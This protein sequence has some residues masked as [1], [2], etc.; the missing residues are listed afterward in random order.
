VTQVHMVDSQFPA[1]QRRRCFL[2]W[3]V[4]LVTLIFFL[5][6]V[7]IKICVSKCSF[8]NYVGFQ[9]AAT[10]T[11][12]VCK[13]SSWQWVEISS[14]ISGF[15][16]FPINMLVQ[17]LWFPPLVAY[18]LVSYKPCYSLTCFQWK[19]MLNCESN[20]ELKS[21]CRSTKAA[22]SDNRLECLC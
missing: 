10:S 16:I 14:Y 7:N 8:D 4:F 9:S 6:Q 20:L 22:S 3:Y 5:L 17:M 13:R 1:E 21:C 2:H 15:V 11:G 12:V 18:S 19:S